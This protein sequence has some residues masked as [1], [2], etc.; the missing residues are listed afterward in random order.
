LDLNSRKFARWLIIG[1]VW[2]TA[3]LAVMLFIPAG[4]LE[5]G[6]GPGWHHRRSL[7][8]HDGVFRENWFVVPG[9]LHQEERQQTLSTPGSTASCGTNVY[10]CVASKIG[11]ALWL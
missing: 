4:T 5:A 8:G 11:T 2:N 7:R 3:S 6:L 10:R 9:V 1:L